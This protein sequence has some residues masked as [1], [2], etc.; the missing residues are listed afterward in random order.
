MYSASAKNRDG[1]DA[2]TRD[3]Q[4]HAKI[5]EISGDTSSVSAREDETS[6]VYCICSKKRYGQMVEC[7]GENCPH[8]NLF[9]LKRVKLKV[10]PTKQ[11]FFHSVGIV[12]KVLLNNQEFRLVFV[13]PQAVPTNAHAL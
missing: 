12:V 9:H 3:G 11:C 4:K 6:D 8:S 10:V 5:P 1:K 7:S 13:A 2:N